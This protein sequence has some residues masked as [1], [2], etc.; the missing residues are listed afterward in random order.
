[1]TRKLPLLIDCISLVCPDNPSVKWGFF[2][3]LFQVLDGLLA[4]YGTVENC[5]QG[6]TE[7]KMPTCVIE[8]IFCPS[9]FWGEEGEDGHAILLCQQK[10]QLKMSRGLS[11]V[12]GAF[13]YCSLLLKDESHAVALG[14]ACACPRI[15]CQVGIIPTAP[16]GTHRQPL[17]G[18]LQDALPR[19][20]GDYLSPLGRFYLSL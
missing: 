13:F 7:K 5:E 17:W 9:Y 18:K 4:Q 11:P 6:R 10:P 1:M 14:S 8:D 16:L 15:G 2:C 19:L 3:S 20:A 12:A